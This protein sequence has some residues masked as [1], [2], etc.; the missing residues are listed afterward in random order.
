ML[1]A[2]PG[3]GVA[4]VAHAA[5][6][7]FGLAV[8]AGEGVASGG[9]RVVVLDPFE[10][11][12]GSVPPGATLVL[13]NPV[14]WVTALARRGWVRDAEDA[15]R[16]LQGWRTL[17]RLWV[18]L[19]VGVGDGLSPA[20]FDELRLEP[21][22]LLEPL[23][24]RWGLEPSPLALDR[25]IRY[26]ERWYHRDLSRRTRWVRRDRPLSERRLRGASWGAVHELL[27][28]DWVAALAARYEWPTEPRRYGVRG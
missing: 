21:I 27:E 24:R 5:A 9:V 22:R 2:T 17:A 6:S 10:P 23:W 14:V 7:G 28:E 26:R 15:A 13:R 16:A 1:V 18:A 8:G 25:A 11:S 20:C 4:I 12:L 19:P 3:S